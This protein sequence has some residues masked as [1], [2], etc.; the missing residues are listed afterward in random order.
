MIIGVQDYDKY[1]H[2]SSPLNDVQRVQRVLEERYGFSVKTLPNPTHLGIMR[3]VNEFNCDEKDND[4][5]CLD[6]DDNL[7]IYFVGRG[8]RLRSGMTETGYWLPVN[9]DPAPNDTLWVPNDFI[10][11][12]LGRIQAKRI[13]V[14]SDSS[15]SD[16]LA[17]EPGLLMVGQGN[18][19]D[20]YIEYKLRKRSRLPLASG[21][22]S[23][24]SMQRL[25]SIRYSRE[26][27]WRRW[28][29]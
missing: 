5:S 19:G 2:L 22:T 17:S 13:L 1:E 18:Y 8:N 21:W 28:K 23:L 26:R 11:R 24:P 15:Y 20:D 3:A 16:L 10:T 12:H 27:S 4:G 14:I 29:K 25:A 7:L 9:A 6:E